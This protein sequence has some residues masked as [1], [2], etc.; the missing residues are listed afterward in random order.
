MLAKSAIPSMRT[1]KLPPHHELSLLCPPSFQSQRLDPDAI[2]IAAKH[3]GRCTTG[4][5]LEHLGLPISRGNEMV[6]A[7]HLRD[8][9][10]VKARV[11]VCG[12]QHWVFFPPLAAAD[13]EPQR[14]D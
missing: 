8:L 2:T 1:G 5:V 14:Y 3:L 6:V 11:M 4:H 12:T 10:Y 7:K 13:A 9:G